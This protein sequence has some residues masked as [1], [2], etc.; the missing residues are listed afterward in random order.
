MCEVEAKTRIRLTDEDIV[1][2]VITA[3]EGGI[4]YWACLDNT[5]EEF[6]N[7]PAYESASETVARILLD[8]GTVKFFDEEDDDRP[9]ILNLDKLLRGVCLFVEQG[10]DQYDVFTGKVDLCN[11]DAI[12][13]D[14][15]F[16]L[17]LFND[18][19]YA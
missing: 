7:A 3:L 18:V 14:Q 12:C 8:G 17:A 9:L 6:K 1:D 15:V 5:G 2:I 10:Y 19:I 11:F 4:G 13:A 16:Q